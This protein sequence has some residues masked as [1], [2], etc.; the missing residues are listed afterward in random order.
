MICTKKLIEHDQLAFVL[1]E[2]DQVGFKKLMIR[3]ANPLIYFTM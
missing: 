2:Q 1:I 3:F